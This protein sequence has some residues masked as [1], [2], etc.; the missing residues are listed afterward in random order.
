[1]LPFTAV[2]LVAHRKRTNLESS[3][4]E[5]VKK[6]GQKERVKIIEA[7]PLIVSTMIATVMDQPATL[8]SVEHP[9]NQIVN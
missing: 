9:K 3:H 2:V 8:R 7:D 4:S 5:M 1:M 6:S